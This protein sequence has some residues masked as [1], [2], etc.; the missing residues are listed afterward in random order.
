V[1]TAIWK[2][3]VV[4]PRMVRRL[5]VEGDRQ[6]DLRG[7]GGENRAIFVYQMSSYRYWSEQLHRDDFVMG[8]FGENFTVDGLSDDD[9]FVGDRYRIGDALFEVT[10]PRVTCYRIGMRMNEPRMPALLVSH[11]KPG[12]YFRVLREGKVKA[13]DPITLVARDDG[14]MSVTA[15]S[16]LL[17][18]PPHPIAEIERATHISALSAGWRSSFQALLQKPAGQNGNPGLALPAQASTAWSGFRPARITKVARD[19]GDVVVLD[20]ESADGEDF[21]KPLPGQFVVVNVRPAS[22]TAPAMRSYSLCGPPNSKYYRLGIKREEGGAVS[23]YFSDDAAADDTVGVSAPRGAFVLHPG[24]NPV[25]LVSVG[26]GATPVLA[27]LY[28]LVEEKSQRAVWWIYGARNRATHPFAAEARA[29]LASSARA[30]SHIRY[31]RPGPSDRVGEDFDSDG[32]IDARL[33]ESLALPPETDFYLC[34]PPEFLNDLGLRLTQIGFTAGQI[35]AEVFGPI[36][37]VNS[38]IVGTTTFR[39]PHQPPEA[40]VSGLSVSFSRSNLRVRWNERYQS[41]LE[42]AEACDVPVRWSCRTGVCHMCESG[43]ISGAVSY[44]PEPL[45]APTH[46]ELLICCARPREDLIIDL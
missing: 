41:I 26:I 24:E 22:A 29:L 35:H 46:G 43:L 40:D 13:G 44:D 10:Q 18:L 34:G 42:L 11:G 12:F 27:M 39:A 3:S 28:S 16:S 15:I 8:Q 20:L 25:A 19:S 33:I 36:G 31:S 37:V 1:H 23:T 21:V 5:N 30:R 9:V 38:G 17:C 7:H 4:G 2:S 14:G 32:H 45:E 6:G